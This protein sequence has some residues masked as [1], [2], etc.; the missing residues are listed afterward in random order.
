MADSKKN[1]VQGGKG[2]CVVGAGL[3]IQTH[4]DSQKCI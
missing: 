4:G 1:R 2:N 3:V